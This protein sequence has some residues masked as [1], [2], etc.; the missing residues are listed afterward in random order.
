MDMD[1]VEFFVVDIIFSEWAYSCFAARG[2][3]N[4]CF[5]GW[6]L[7]GLLALKQNPFDNGCSKNFQL[8]RFVQK[9]CRKTIG[10]IS[11]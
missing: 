11:V 1:F 6:S 3:G 8:R 4:C 9:E 5:D 2:D 7:C 10:D